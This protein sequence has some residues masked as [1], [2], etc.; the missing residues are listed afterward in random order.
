MN[1][2]SLNRLDLLPT[3]VSSQIMEELLAL[4]KTDGSM[5]QLRSR[6]YLLRYAFNPNIQPQVLRVSK[7]LHVLGKSV[8]DQANKWV[9]VDMDEA[10][11]LTL[12]ASPVL[13]MIAVD[14]ESAQDLPSGMMHIRI[15]PYTRASAFT[16]H[17][18]RIFSK[19]ENPRQI[20]LLPASQISEFVTALRITELANVPRLLH[21][22]PFK[23]THT[24][25]E[26]RVE[27]GKHGLSVLIHVNE[28]YPCSVIKSCLEEFRRLHGPLNEI[29]VIGNVDEQQARSIE[30][31]IPL[32]RDVVSEGTF[33]EVIIHIMDLISM[34]DTKAR[35]GMA[36]CVP[37]L[38][39]QARC[40][41]VNMHRHDRTPW[42]GWANGTAPKDPTFDMIVM[43]AS[44]ANL[45]VHRMITCTDWLFP[46]AQKIIDRHL[47]PTF[48]GLLQQQGV[49]PQLS[50]Y[51]WLLNGLSCVLSAR[52]GPGRHTEVNAIFHGLDL[53]SVSKAFVSQ[54]PSHERRLFDAAYKM[55]G[56]ISRVGPDPHKKPKIDDYIAV[57]AKWFS[58]EIR[59]LK[60]RVH[61]SH[62]PQRLRNKGAL[63]K[64]QKEELLSNEEL[65]MYLIIDTLVVEEGAEGEFYLL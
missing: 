50:A 23:N 58:E 63:S 42:G 19:S 64:M 43:C 24:N 30:A 7:K 32:P 38:Y 9:L 55:H 12:W 21:G 44:S 34:A 56:Y 61:E 1:S 27:R 4:H 29:S 62:V 11:L 45:M 49:R 57:F 47:S 14:P 25:E 13:E 46:S 51:A 26:F 10:Y 37:K 41:V 52:V 17:R 65:D 28:G 53:I 59:P 33:S 8:L 6:N 18:T 20:F 3:E 35:Q 48:Q 16:H 60:W 5:T 40:M 36:A 31:S 15:K 2:Q 54:I 39:E 22:A